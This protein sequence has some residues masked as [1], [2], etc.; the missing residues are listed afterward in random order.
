MRKIIP[1]ILAAVLPGC[2]SIGQTVDHNESPVQ[3]YRTKDGETVRISGTLDRNYL[4]MSKYS[5]DVKVYFGDQLV[6]DGAINDDYVG[7]LGGYWR[8]KPVDLSCSGTKTTRTNINVRCLVF[9]DNERAVT[10]TF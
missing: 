7:E 3:T 4:G 2:I 10:L 8:N 9:V 6:I 1:L 5:R